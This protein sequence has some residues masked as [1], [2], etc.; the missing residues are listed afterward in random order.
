MRRGEQGQ[1]G[2]YNAS[3]YEWVS[4]RYFGMRIAR[5]AELTPRV[6]ETIV[7]E[8][9][10]RTRVEL[11]VKGFQEGGRSASVTGTD[12]SA[13]ASVSRPA[14]EPGSKPPEAGRAVQS[15]S[16]QPEAGRAAQSTSGQ[17][18]AGRAVQSTSGQSETIAAPVQSAV[19]QSVSKPLSELYEYDAPDLPASG[20][21][22]P[23]RELSTGR[24][25]L[26][27]HYSGVPAALR[28]VLEEQWSHPLAPVGGLCAM[29]NI[30]A[31]EP[32]GDFILAR[33]YPPAEGWYAAGSPALRGFSEKALF[34][35]A[36]AMMR[37]LDG[38]LKQGWLPVR[39]VEAHM[40]IRPQTGEARFL[41][42]AWL[43][44]ENQAPLECTLGYR[45]PQA[46]DEGHLAAVSDAGF[47]AA[48]WLYRL[49]IGGYPMEGA[50][51]RGALL[52]AERAAEAGEGGIPVREEDFAPSL[53]GREALFVFDPVN[54]GNA[55]EKLGG[56]YED[57]IR[58]WNSMPEALRRGWTRTFSEC[59]HRD[60]ERRVS[61]AEWA[62]ILKKSGS[63]DA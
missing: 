51:T 52:E 12:R 15:T 3:E 14:N 1:I 48:V 31:C 17:S 13:S 54:G 57:Q 20:H 55:I 63:A 11:Q 18:E 25:V 29:V 21:S 43:A 44:G 30:H 7:I 10:D 47:C 50:K 41:D 32:Q 39:F 36:E 46:Y 58:R 61:P 27:E 23:A 62:E 2:L 37:L 53:Y 6:N 34:A 8:L 40:L 56:A 38:V 5:G 4:S 42:G 35:A 59:L 28:N 16:G 24:R 9:R 49:L 22:I 19:S 33:A 26:L 45:A 60:T